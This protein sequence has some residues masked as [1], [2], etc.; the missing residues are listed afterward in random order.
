MPRPNSGSPAARHS[1]LISACSA[2][3]PAAAAT[4]R[5]A[6]SGCGNGAP[7]TA[8]TASPTNCMTVPSSPRIALFIAARCRFSCP[9]SC[10][11]VGLLRDRRV[12]PDVA[13][14]HGDD[15]PLGLA[16]PQ[17]PSRAACRPGPRAAAGTASRPAPC[18]RR[19]PGAAGAAGTAPPGRPPTPRWRASRTPPPPRRRPP[20]AAAARRAAIALIVRPSAISPS[21]SSSAALSPPGATTGRTS[22]STIAGSSAVPPVATALIASASWVPSATRSLSR[23]P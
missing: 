14:Q 20:T 7:N 10:G 23:Y 16:D 19:S 4:A 17:R 6:W 2:C 18:R 9:A 1:A 11:R 22:A 3:M 12:R 8:I 21:S 13:H 15:D 5:S